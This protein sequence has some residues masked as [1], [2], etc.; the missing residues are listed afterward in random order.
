MI[1]YLI[2][3]TVS[4]ILFGVL[5]G[6]IKRVTFRLMRGGELVGTGRITSLRKVDKDIKEAKEGT[7][8]GM[9]VETSLP[10][11]EGDILEAFNKEL[12]RRE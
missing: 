1:R 8:C 6:V 10:V 2:V 3:S 4:G 5:D 7:E 9:R 12:K 11:L